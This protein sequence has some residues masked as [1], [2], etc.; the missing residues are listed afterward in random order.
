M[1]KIEING[2]AIEAAPGS[3]ILDAA[4]KAGIDIP[5]LCHDWRLHPAGE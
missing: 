4:H 5:T 3:T 1:P 2:Q